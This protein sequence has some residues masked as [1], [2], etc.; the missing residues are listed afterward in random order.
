MKVP[1]RFGPRQRWL[2]STLADHMGCAFQCA[3]LQNDRHVLLLSRRF[4]SHSTQQR[5]IRRRYHR[6]CKR[7]TLIQPTITNR[8]S[9]TSPQTG[10]T[11]GASSFRIRRSTRTSEMLLLLDRLIWSARYLPSIKYSL[12]ITTLSPSQA[13]TIQNRPI[14]A[15]HGSLG[16]NRTFPRDVAHEMPPTVHPPTA[17]SD[18]TTY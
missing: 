3:Q 6:R 11:L 7:H 15:I 5:R 17:D 13:K 9:R 14:R 10:P 12:P 1:L 8:A 18:S 2:S 4:K 16:V